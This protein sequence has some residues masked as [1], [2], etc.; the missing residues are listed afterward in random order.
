MT[1]LHEGIDVEFDILIR[2][3]H[4]QRSGSI[5][6]LSGQ[7]NGAGR[8]FCQPVHGVNYSPARLNFSDCL[9]L[10][11]HVLLPKQKMHAGSRRLDIVDHP[12]DHRLAGDIDERLGLNKARFA[13]A[14]AFARGGYD[15]IHGLRSDIGGNRTPQDFIL[16]RTYFIGRIE[17]VILF[18]RHRPRANTTSFEDHFVQR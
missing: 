5:E 11:L 17:A 3:R 6:G 8:A 14:T 4:E 1:V 10:R 13:E 18:L 15:E 16:E 9:R 12:L 2:V 7:K